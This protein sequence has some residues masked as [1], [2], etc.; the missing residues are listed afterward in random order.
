MNTMT[1]EAAN[2]GAA[3]EERRRMLLAALADEAVDD[4]VTELLFEHVVQGRLHWTVVA[5]SL[6]PILSEVTEV[7]DESDWIDAAD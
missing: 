1:P 2:V 3:G 7:A 4:A 5:N 6:A